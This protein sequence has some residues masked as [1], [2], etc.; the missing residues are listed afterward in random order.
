MGK[1]KQNA[2]CKSKEKCNEQIIL[3]NLRKI[4]HEQE[5][6]PYTGGGGRGGG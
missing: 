6:C 2:I 1:S 4:R 3:K 5:T